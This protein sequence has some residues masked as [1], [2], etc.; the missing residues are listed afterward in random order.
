LGYVPAFHAF[1][2]LLQGQAERLGDL[3][4][5]TLLRFAAEQDH[6][7]SQLRL[8]EMYLDG[9]WDTTPDREQARAWYGKALAKQRAP[10][11]SA[12]RPRVRSEN[13]V[14]NT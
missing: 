10:K 2:L 9:D 11:A 5:V 3:D 13:G 8:G 6:P 1:A 7:R 4:G 14:P 12:T